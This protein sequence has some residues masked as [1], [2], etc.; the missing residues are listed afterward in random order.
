MDTWE[1]YFYWFSFLVIFFFVAAFS[2]LIEP[3]QS[4]F[5]LNTEDVCF[6]SGFFAATSYFFGLNFRKIEFVTRNPLAKTFYFLSGI[7]WT[8]ICLICIYELA[9]TYKITYLIYCVPIIA[10]IIFG[11]IGFVGQSTLMWTYALLS[12]GLYGI[13]SLISN[14]DHHELPYSIS[15]SF[16]LLGLILILLSFV[17]KF[18]K[19]LKIFTK[20]TFVI[21]YL[22]MLFG[23]ILI[24]KSKL[25]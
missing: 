4:F 17:F 8:T 9:C 25:F 2:W 1:E 3:I 13:Y 7:S 20:S 22:N 21:G 10:F 24:S 5:P 18:H 6:L 15:L 14:L 19:K 12:L 16:M 11:I 23:T